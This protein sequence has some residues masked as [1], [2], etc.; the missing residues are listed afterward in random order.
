MEKTCTKNLCIKTWRTTISASGNLFLYVVGVSWCS[1]ELHG[2]FTTLLLLLTAKN[3]QSTSPPKDALPFCC[4]L[5]SI[6]KTWSLKHG[7]CILGCEVVDEK[8]KVARTQIALPARSPTGNPQTHTAG[9]QSSGRYLTDMQWHFVCTLKIFMCSQLQNT[10]CDKHI[11]TQ[12]I[13]WDNRETE[14][15]KYLNCTQ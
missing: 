4:A 9:T 6:M 14:Q 2:M 7:F 13:M 11:Q 15:K 5:K 12:K 1:Q 10:C 8:Y 3:K